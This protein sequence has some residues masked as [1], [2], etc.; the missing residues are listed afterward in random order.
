MGKYPDLA[1]P[2]VGFAQRLGSRPLV[3]EAGLVQLLLSLGQRPL[4]LGELVPE[5][6]YALILGLEPRECI[7]VL[8]PAGS[9]RASI[10]YAQELP[11]PGSSDVSGENEKQ[12]G[13]PNPRALASFTSVS[14]TGRSTSP[15]SIR[16]IYAAKVACDFAS[17]RIER[18]ARTRAALVSSAIVS[19]AS[20]C[21]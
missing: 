1:Q 6:L 3:L 4:S 14:A 5:P 8:G 16:L 2:L 10:T 12:V 11:R 18:R 21:S 15:A 7:G 17:P 19:S 9:G 13:V 20:V